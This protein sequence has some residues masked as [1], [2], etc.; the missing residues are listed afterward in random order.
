MRCRI[1][2]PLWL[3]AV[4]L[5][6]ALA[7][8]SAQL[9][10]V[11]VTIALLLALGW[12]AVRWAAATLTVETGTD[13][14]SVRRGGTVS[15]TMTVHHR[16]LL[17]MQPAEIEWTAGPGEEAHVRAVPQRLHPVPL[18]FPF[19]AAHVGVSVPGVRCCVLRSLFGCFEM[20]IRDP[21]VTSG[22]TVLPEAIDMPPLTFSPGDRGMGTM[23]VATEDA[24]DPMDVRAWQEGDSLKKIHWKLSARRRELLVR[25]FEEPTLP[26]AQLLLD[27][28]RPEPGADEACTRDALL[29]TAAG[30]LRT[31]SRESCEVILPLWGRRPRE[32]SLRMGLPVLD[33]E[34]A[35]VDFSAEQDYLGQLTEAARGL[36]QVGATVA[37]T[38]RLDSPLAD[39][40]IS[41]RRQGPTLRLC[42]VTADPDRGDWAPLVAGLR[43]HGI[44]V[45][46]IRPDAP[47]AKS[48]QF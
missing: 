25:R 3:A 5:V 48:E 13:T 46:F 33:E 19:R 24:T 22:L 45:C 7:L 32:L 8:G 39:L 26:E 15:L 6:L 36:R 27:C 42:L 40:L 11:P 14:P 23:A 21:G 10:A 9:L 12:I 2:A 47:P 16:C 31:Q 1:G 37:V 20:E 41:M 34:L 38:S 17:P 43:L 35:R 4:S 29:E 30:I 44:E 28:S 18:E